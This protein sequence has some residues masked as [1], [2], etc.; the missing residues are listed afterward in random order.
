MIGSTDRDGA[1]S[2]GLCA[3]LSCWHA[4]GLSGY[5]RVDLRLDANGVPWVLEINA[6]PCLSSDAGF[7]AAGAEAGM[8]QAAIVESVLRAALE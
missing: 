5:A 1:G 3:A 2:R 7:V 6:N 8:T 4:F